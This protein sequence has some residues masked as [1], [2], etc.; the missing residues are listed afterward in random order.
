MPPP[1]KRP[2]KGAAPGRVFQTI[3]VGSEGEEWLVGRARKFKDRKYAVANPRFREPELQYIVKHLQ[4]H[5]IAVKAMGLSQLVDEMESRGW[6]TRNVNIDMPDTG[7]TDR[8]DL[9]DFP[10]LFSHAKNILLPGGKIFMSSEN[11]QFLARVSGEAAK[12]GVKSR[13]RPALDSP[14]AMR[15]EYMK[16]RNR[17]GGLVYRVELW[18][19]KPRPEKRK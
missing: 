19:H 12:H 8:K 17:A 1:G 16:S 14:R 5:G 7:G 18:V 10:K 2:F 3:D 13:V 11:R 4:E 9:Y 15:T 6:R